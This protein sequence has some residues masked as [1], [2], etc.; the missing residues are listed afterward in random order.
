MIRTGDEYRAGLRDGREVWIDG[1]RVTDVT[2]HAAFRPIVDS[3]ARMYDLAH[4]AAAAPVM[5]FAE[6]DKRFSTLLRPSTEAEH[7]REKW[8]AIDLYL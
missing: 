2:A 8:R 5:S 1:E 6:D 4:D 7:W 3:K